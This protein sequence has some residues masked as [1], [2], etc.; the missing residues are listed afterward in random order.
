MDLGT[1]VKRLKCMH[2]TLPKDLAPSAASLSAN[3]IAESVTREFADDVLL[4]FD[5]CMTYNEEGSDPFKAAKRLKPV[6]RALTKRSSSN[7]DRQ[8]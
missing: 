4:T 8:A 5:N 6:L 1:V 3:A 2:Y 7:S